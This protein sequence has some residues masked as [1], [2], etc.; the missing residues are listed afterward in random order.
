MAGLGGPPNLVP[1]IFT[2][3]AFF[4]SPETDPFSGSYEAVLEPS[5]IYPMNADAAQTTG[6]VSQ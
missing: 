4:S 1:A 2:Y 6:S 5:R 3:C